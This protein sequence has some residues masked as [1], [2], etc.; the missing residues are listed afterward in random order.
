MVTFTS[1][2]L[3][4]DDLVVSDI[5]S[6][7]LAVGR[8]D[9]PYPGVFGSSRSARFIENPRK[10]R[11]TTAA[12][13][14]QYLAKCACA[15]AANADQSAENDRHL[16]SLCG[17]FTS[18]HT[19]TPFSIKSRCVQIIFTGRNWSFGLLQVMFL[20]PLCPWSTAAG[21]RW[22]QKSANRSKSQ[23]VPKSLP[24]SRVCCTSRA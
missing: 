21:V 23:E 22:P 20:K 19:V 2:A 12:S 1:Q 5:T 13:T 14:F 15:L 10:V 18:C 16:V 6:A 3:S 8:R 11:K 7:F 24:S 4:S 17:L 9:L